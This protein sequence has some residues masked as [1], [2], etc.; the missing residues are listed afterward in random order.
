VLLSL[1][2]DGKEVSAAYTFNLLEHNGQPSYSWST[3]DVCPMIKN[4]GKS[5]VPFIET[6]FLESRTATYLRG[7]CLRVRFDVN[8]QGAQMRGQRR[9][10][11]SGRRATARQGRA[12]RPPPLQRCRGRPHIRGRRGDVRHAQT[13]TDRP[14]TAPSG[15]LF[16]LVR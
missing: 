7:D 11:A 4:H 5:V 6:K 12:A 9:A 2:R 13:H 1:R 10:V 15:R 14:V 3:A 8:L 16:L